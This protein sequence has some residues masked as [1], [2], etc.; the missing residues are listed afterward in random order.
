METAQG[1]KIFDLK[2]PKQFKRLEKR[3]TSDLLF[4]SIFCNYQ[5]RNLQYL[6]VYCIGFIN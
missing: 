6:F 5:I 3:I 4:L 1:R 2:I